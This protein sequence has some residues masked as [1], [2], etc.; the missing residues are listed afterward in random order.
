M[1]VGDTLLISYFAVEYYTV[2]LLL[3]SL[4]PTHSFNAGMRKFAEYWPTCRT[5][6]V[7]LVILVA[8]GTV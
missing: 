6:L 2:E 5:L 8:H 3:G 1:Q 7:A 4:L